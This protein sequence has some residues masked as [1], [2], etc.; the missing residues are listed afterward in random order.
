MNFSVLQPT[1]FMQTL[2]S[3]WKAAV[4]TG[5]FGLPY[6]PTKKAS[7]V[8][9]RDVAEAGAIALTG[10]T[11]SYGTFELP[12][13][14]IFDRIEVAK[15]MSEALGRKRAQ[16]GF[17]ASRW[18]TGPAPF[19]QGYPANTRW[20]TPDLWIRRTVTLPATIPPQLMLMTQHDEDVEVYINGIAAASATGFEGQYVPLKMD[21]AARA[22]LKPGPNV[23]AAHCRQT[24]G[25]QVLDV[26]IVAGP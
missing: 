4:K 1:M 17:D 9:Y 26:G 19:G 13:R 11:L 12:A 18:K 24:V 21:A 16:P 2:E 8:D 22:S 25:G 14:G 3:S 6:D 23:I 20:K 15:T 5:T 10:D 7:Y